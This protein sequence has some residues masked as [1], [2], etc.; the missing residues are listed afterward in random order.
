MKRQAGPSVRRDWCR[1][2]VEG[3]VS[4]GATFTMLVLVDRTGSGMHAA[5]AGRA[6]IGEVVGKMANRDR[7]Y[8]VRQVSR[9]LAELTAAGWLDTRHRW[10]ADAPTAR[11]TALRSLSA[12]L[13]S[14]LDRLA[15]KRWRRSSS[16][17]KP[18]RPAAVVDVWGDVDENGYAVRVERGPPANEA[19]TT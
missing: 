4:F 11:C 8:S 13:L 12:K 14:E 3:T 5:W 9:W 15:G 1:Q 2:V 16:D 6:H 18:P 10:H 19:P 17:A 7:P